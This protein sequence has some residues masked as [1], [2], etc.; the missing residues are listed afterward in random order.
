MALQHEDVWKLLTVNRG[1]FRRI[2]HL[3]P[4]K[5]GQRN[6][7]VREVLAFKIL[8]TLVNQH[9][10][11]LVGME[12]LTMDSFFD[13]IKKRHHKELKRSMVLWHT[14]ENYIKVVDKSEKYKKSDYN[15]N[16]LRLKKLYKDYLVQ[17]GELGYTIP[18]AN[19][20]RELSVVEG[21]K[22]Q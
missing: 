13:E 11:G 12:T 3:H 2:R 17:T 19:T 5:E 14:T 22:S 9:V 21:G 16:V 4:N 20:H 7:S 10:P 1:K 15:L 6:Y 8:L 18:I